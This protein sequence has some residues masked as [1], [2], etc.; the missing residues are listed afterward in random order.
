MHTQ[1]FHRSCIAICVL[2]LS[3]S[4]I[5][6]TWPDDT[7]H[8]YWSQGKAEISRYAL[9]QSR[10]G[11]LHKGDAVLIFVTEP[12]SKSKQVKLDDWQ[13]AGDDLVQVL[14]LNFTKKFLTGIYPYSLMFSSFTP[15]DGSPTLKT[16]ITGQEWCGHVF[17]QLNRRANHFEMVNYSYFESEGD[18]RGELPLNL[19]EDEIWAKLRLTPDQLPV[20]ELE[21]IP[22][23]FIS[24]LLHVPLKAEKAR[25]SWMELDSK[26]GP[27]IR[28]YRLEYLSG[29]QRT[30]TIWFERDLPH[31]LVSWD[32]TYSEFGK[33]PLT[34]HAERTSTLMSDY[35]A[36]HLNADRPLRQKLD[37]ST[38]N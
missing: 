7:M 23:S 13:N 1:F 2:I 34:T 10:Y 24:R 26:R 25:A 5:G 22:G 9:T 38:E 27:N 36:H 15:V 6:Q 20:G 37:L 4:A 12:F 11:E 31:G 21:I 32:D 3:H 33:P 14:K 17:G 18:T 30:L 28:G 16:T 8:K 35:W 29:Y 19:L